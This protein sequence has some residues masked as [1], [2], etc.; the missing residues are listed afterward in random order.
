MIAPISHNWAELCLFGSCFLVRNYIKEIEGEASLPRFLQIHT[1]GLILRIY[2]ILILSFWSNQ[3]KIWVVEGRVAN[4]I[5]FTKQR[6]SENKTYCCEIKISESVTGCLCYELNINNYSQFQKVEVQISIQLYL[7]LLCT[8]KRFQTF[9]NQ[10]STCLSQIQHLKSYWK[11]DYFKNKL[12]LHWLCFWKFL[13]LWHSPASSRERERE[14]KSEWDCYW[15]G[16]L[17]LF[18]QDS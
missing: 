9:S 1:S 4:S 5:K 11:F 7:T 10:H 6:F 3:S 12:F 15:V 14:R 17:M 16:R 18:Q 13:Q 2:L 8:I